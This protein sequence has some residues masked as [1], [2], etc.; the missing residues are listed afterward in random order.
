M[1]YNTVCALSFIRLQLT[2]AA[3]RHELP[4]RRIT[5]YKTL[6]KHPLL[7]HERVFDP[8]E[9]FIGIAVINV[10]Q[11]TQ[12]DASYSVRKSQ[13]CGWGQINPC[14]PSMSQRGGTIQSCLGSAEQSC[15][16][17][18]FLSLVPNQNSNQHFVLSNKQ[19]RL[20]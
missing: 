8:G 16:P 11:T 18:P 20:I 17:I 5:A 13:G 19:N 7:M 9:T 15:R 4:D 3:I 14:L 6:T 12:L 1:K 10:P 2:L